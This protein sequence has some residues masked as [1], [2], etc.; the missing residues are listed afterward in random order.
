MRF[1]VQT[2]ACGRNEY[3]AQL[4]SD[5]LPADEVDF[6]NEDT[7]DEECDNEDTDQDSEETD[8]ETNHDA[9]V[10]SGSDVEF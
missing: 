5:T 4:R 1:D 6:S 7:S 3:N 2:E 8:A 9:A 10:T